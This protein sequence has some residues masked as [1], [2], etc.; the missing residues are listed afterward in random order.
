MRYLRNMKSLLVICLIF[1]A[2]Y[3]AHGQLGLESQVGGANFLG[4]SVNLA[5]EKKLSRE[6]DVVLEP[7]VGYGILLPGWDVPTDILHAGL[8]IRFNRFGSG[9]EGSWFIK[10]LFLKPDPTQFSD[11]IQL[12]VYPNVNYRIIDRTNWYLR[13]SAGV[14]VAFDRQYRYPCIDCDPTWKLSFAGDAIPGAGINF[15]YKIGQRKMQ[16]LKHGL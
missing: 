6:K 16:K 8:N 10:S 5:T 9:I 1:L 2:V 13:V 4:V 3:S 14:M 11:F 12:L 7:R 15:G